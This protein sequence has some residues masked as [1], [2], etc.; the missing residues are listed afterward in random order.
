MYSPP[1]TKE[2]VAPPPP[3]KLCRTKEAVHQDPRPK[4]VTRATEK[5][6]AAKA[7][8]K[9]KNVKSRPKKEKTQVINNFIMLHFSLSFVQN[10]QEIDFSRIVIIDR[11]ETEFKKLRYKYIFLII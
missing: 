2:E 8:M 9:Q 5:R 1:V 10:S 3:P 11:K 7:L 4:R 6:L